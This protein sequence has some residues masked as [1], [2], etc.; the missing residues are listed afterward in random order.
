MRGELRDQVDEALGRQGG[1]VVRAPG[2]RDVAG[3]ADR[4]ALRVPSPSP[5]AGGS[6]PYVQFLDAEGNISAGSTPACPR[7][8]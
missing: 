1:L 7:S 5:R 4:L 8:R 6:A 3:A 2:G